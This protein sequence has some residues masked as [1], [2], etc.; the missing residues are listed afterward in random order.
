[1]DNNGFEK[2]APPGWEKI[3]LAV[4]NS[5]HQKLSRKLDAWNRKLSQKLDEN[6]NDSES[7]ISCEIGNFC[8]EVVAVNSTLV[9]S[10]KKIE[11]EANCE[12][13]SEVVELNISQKGNDNKSCA[14]N[15]DRIDLCEERVESVANSGDK[16]F[17][18]QEILYRE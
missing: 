17:V 11:A 15:H 6:Y 2:S 3:I 1:M 7:K 5:L 16:S 12:N 18:C 13:E 9:D 14:T 10:N 8:H 4:L